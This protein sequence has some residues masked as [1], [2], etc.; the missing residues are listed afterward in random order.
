M[1]GNPSVS[2]LVSSYM[3]SLRRRKVQGG[4][5]ATSARA[6]TPEYIGRMYDFN[7][8]PENWN[9][10]PYQP[11]KRNKDNE[12]RQWGGPRFRRQLHLAYTIAHSC[13]LRVDEVLKIQ[14]HEI[15]LLTIMIEVQPFYLFALPSS[16]KHLCP[17]RAYA[18]W[19]NLTQITEGYIFWKMGSGDRISASPGAQLVRCY[20]DYYSSLLTSNDRAR[21]PFLQD[22]VKISLTLV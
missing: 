1:K 19:I 14:A 13:L 6:I 9:I 4:E 3:V 11:S 17:I 21:R 10:R 20:L 8:R 16:L 5:A 12:N 22:S 2:S 7:H 15:R 18:D